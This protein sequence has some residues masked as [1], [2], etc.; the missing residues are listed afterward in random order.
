MQKSDSQG[1][2]LIAGRTEDPTMAQYM[3][4][5]GDGSSGHAL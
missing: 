5:H 4:R 1:I 3:L 2:L